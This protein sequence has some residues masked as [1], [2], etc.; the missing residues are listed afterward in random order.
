MK[1][2]LVKIAKYPIYSGLRC[3]ATAVW[4]P[5]END[6]AAFELPREHLNR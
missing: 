5:L 4:R 1:T 2:K 3:Q 6:P